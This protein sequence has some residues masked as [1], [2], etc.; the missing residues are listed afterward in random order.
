MIPTVSIIIP[1]YKVE[2]YLVECIESILNQTYKDFELLLIDDG[3]PDC[4]PQ[5]CENFAKKDPRI[6]VIHKKNGGLSDA[7]NSGLDI[8]KGN[9]IMFV[10]SDDFISTNA[11]EILINVA[12]KHTADIVQAEATRDI[13]KLGVVIESPINTF[14]SGEY[15][16]TDYL[17]K[18]S[19]KDMA[20]AKLYRRNLFDGIRYPV[21][22]YNEDT[23]TTYK[24]LLAAKKVV[25]IS[26]PI[27][28]YRINNNGITHGDYN[29]KHFAA[30]DIPKQIKNYLGENS[31]RYF[32]E[33]HYFQMKCDF[34]LYNNCIF[35]GEDQNHPEEIIKLRQSLRTEYK[36]N[37]MWKLHHK[38]LVLMLIYFPEIYKKIVIEFR[39]CR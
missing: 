12:K 11:L 29:V 24:L 14:D 28:F 38:L 16:F 2:K 30:H 13:S 15:A 17:V 34:D 7:R 6:I 21:G 36:Y 9:Y 35:L 26:S 19:I 18:H 8:A 32:Y 1:V 23:L 39:S 37:R 3:S 27:Y 10:D 25:C 22:Q 5:I 4:C 20:W 31:N 33:L